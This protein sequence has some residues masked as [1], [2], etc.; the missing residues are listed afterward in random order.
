MRSFDHCTVLDHMAVE[1]PIS[2]S[3]NRKR[4]VSPEQIDDDDDDVSSV[5]SFDDSVSEGSEDDEYVLR[6]V[7]SLRHHCLHLLQDQEEMSL[8]KQGRLRGN[9]CN[10]PRQPNSRTRNH[11]QLLS[12]EM[13][14]YGISKILSL[15]VQSQ[16]FFD[17][18][19]EEQTKKAFLL[20]E[21]FIECDWDD[22]ADSFLAKF[23]MMLQ[24]SV[25]CPPHII[26]VVSRTTTQPQ[27]T[28]T[29]ICGGH[30]PKQL[31]FDTMCL[32][33]KRRRRRQLID[34]SRGELQ[35][36]SLLTTDLLHQ[37]LA[38]PLDDEII[39]KLD[40][41][42]ARTD[43]LHLWRALIQ[44]QWVLTTDEALELFQDTLNPT[45]SVESALWNF[46]YYVSLYDN[47]NE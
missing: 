37:R 42:E 22:F 47:N 1:T 29:S 36:L 24:R 14:K 20:L 35:R 27:A 43:I 3:K 16:S 11:A 44:R 40:V 6:T 32:Q 8:M 12:D 28:S 33:Q 23:H 21:Q 31:C 38:A 41:I 45:V 13:L 17:K 4:W 25:P 7:T 26:V 19:Q 46:V 2:Q 18:L 9:F 39:D 5:T 10:P 34:R 15:L 30:L